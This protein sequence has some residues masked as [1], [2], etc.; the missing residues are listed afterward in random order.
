[1]P[2]DGEAEKAIAAINGTDLEGLGKAI[3]V[4]WI[5]PSVKTS[6]GGMLSRPTN[7]WKRLSGGKHTFQEGRFLAVT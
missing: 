7:T 5:V 1:M 4:P 6:A 3:I 2:N